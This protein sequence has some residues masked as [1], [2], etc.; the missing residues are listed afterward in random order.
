MKFLAP[1]YVIVPSR[2]SCW[3]WL[4]SLAILLSARSAW[5]HP[6]E[7]FV[8]V[9]ELVA[10]QAGDLPILLSAPH[11]G[12]LEIPG[13]PPR[14]GEGLPRGG[15]GFST[16]RDIGTEQLARDV[17]EEIER[18]F[19]KKPYFVISRV[20]RRYV[21]PNR[22]PRIAYEDQSAKPVYDR[23]HDSL[24]R[25]CREALDRF[26]GGLLLDLHGQGVHPDAVLR[27]TKNGLTVKLL[28]ERYGEAAHTGPESLFGLLQSRGWIVHPHPGDGKEQTGYDGGY[29]VQTYGS[30]TAFAIDAMQLEFGR[31]YRTPKA[32]RQTARVLVDALVQYA[33]RYLKL[34]AAAETKSQASPI[35]VAV[36]L[37]PGTGGSKESL[38]KLI[39][40]WPRFH[41]K[42]LDAA[43]I[44]AGKLEGC[45]AL[46]HPGGSGG[47]QGRALEAAGRAQVRSF[48][49]SGGGYLGICAGAYLA[50]CDYPWSLNILDA[51]VLDRRHW[52]RGFGLVDIRLSSHGREMLGAKQSVETIYYHQG[53]LLA[54]ADNPDIDDFE[55]LA[56]F[57]GDIAQ[58]GAP[59]GVMP[60]TTAIA[61]GTHGRGR[62][63]CFSPHPEKTKGLEFLLER[64][65]EWLVAPPGR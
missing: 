44:R 11:G 21:D 51:K 28:R 50:T 37:G 52:D 63:I 53:P 46:V 38:L 4:V 8:S 19:G 58:K 56:V 1:R 40:A 10:V 13:V 12:T 14:V 31:E 26:G 6:P 25:F 5:C 64:A 48:V 33:E 9:K 20:R 32:R 36:Y 54:P 60:G 55:S 17:A 18:R 41:I 3:K 65:L 42:Q 49:A 15:A 35:K 23:Y 30:Q 2:K 7:S 62:V 34:K 57:V 47:G 27:G 45:R 24:A 29:I 39:D 43:D 59:P 61:A 22:P 16:S